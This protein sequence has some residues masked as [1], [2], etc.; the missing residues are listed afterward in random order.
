MRMHSMPGRRGVA[1]IGLLLLPSAILLTGCGS[2]EPEPSAPGYYSGAMQ[3]KSAAA[4]TGGAPA[5]AP[6]TSKSGAGKL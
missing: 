3:P 1:L 4:S 5:N 2:K 6:G